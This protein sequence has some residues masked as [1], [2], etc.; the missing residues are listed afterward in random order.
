M[1]MDFN[2]GKKTDEMFAPTPSVLA[3]RWIVSRT[4]SQGWRGGG[5]KRLMAVDFTKAFLYGEM[6]REVYIELPDEDERKQ[7][8]D[9]VGLLLKAMYGLRDAPLIWQKLVQNMLVQRGFEVLASAQ[10][11]YINRETGVIVVAH[12]DDFLCHG[13]HDELGSF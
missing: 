4:A 13:D 12:V 3:S 2:K 11:V 8:G 1:A 5:R 9:M 10:C 6:E 7:K